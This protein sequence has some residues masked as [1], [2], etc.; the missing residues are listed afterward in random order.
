MP[1]PVGTLGYSFSPDTSNRL[2]QSFNTGLLPNNASEALR[3]L[4]LHLPAML[5]GS[6]IAPEALLRPSLP[7]GRRPIGAQPFNPTVPPPTA[8]PVA[9]QPFTG[10]PTDTTGPSGGQGGSSGTVPAIGYGYGGK[11]PSIPQPT[12]S[13]GNDISDLLR[14]LF[15]GYDVGGGLGRA[16]AGGGRFV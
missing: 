14:S 3:I 11:P 6:P 9:R 12:P 15:S 8:G 4:S 16:S 10:A 5:G 1:D 2:R 7:G 13:G